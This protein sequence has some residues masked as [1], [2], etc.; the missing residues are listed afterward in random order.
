MAISTWKT[1][2]EWPQRSNRP[3]FHISGIRVYSPV[4]ITSHLSRLLTDTVNCNG[5][6]IQKYSDSV[7]LG[8]SLNFH[9]AVSVQEASIN[10][11]VKSGG[12]HERKQKPTEGS[13]CRFSKSSYKEDKNCRHELR[14]KIKLANLNVSIVQGRRAER[15]PYANPEYLRLP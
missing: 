15:A 11:R 4:S 1:W 2:C 8:P 12:S 9:L 10:D 14:R 5:S 6:Q 13:P 3:G 7:A